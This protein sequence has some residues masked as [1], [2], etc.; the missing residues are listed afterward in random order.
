MLGDVLLAVEELWPESLAEQWDAVG[1]VVGRHAPVRSILFA[2]DPM[3][4][5]IDEALTGA[6]TCWSPTIRCC[7]SR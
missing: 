2:V 3:A 4:D 6:R 1:P 7:S 5:V